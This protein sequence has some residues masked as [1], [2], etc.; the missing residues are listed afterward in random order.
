MRDER[1]D[2]DPV[3]V[4][5]LQNALRAHD[6]IRLCY[7]TDAD[8]A[9]LDAGAM[10]KDFKIGMESITRMDLRRLNRTASFQS[11]GGGKIGKCTFAGPVITKRYG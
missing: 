7:E 11:K 5:A 4:P 3:V 8:F 9:G 2:Y 1:A 6:K 10:R